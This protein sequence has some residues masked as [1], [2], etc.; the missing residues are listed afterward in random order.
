MSTFGLNSDQYLIKFFS[1]LPINEA[2]YKKTKHS[3]VT[4][5]RVL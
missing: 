4:I 5:T 2:L 3:N 1:V